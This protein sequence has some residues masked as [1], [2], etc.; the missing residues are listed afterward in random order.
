MTL[1]SPQSE[2]RLPVVSAPAENS[3]R[4]LWSASLVQCRRLLI[5][6]SRDWTTTVQALV[7]PALMMLMFLI[8]FG[9]T[10][11]EATGQRAVYG[12][13]P[14]V[15]L[16]AAMSGG[17]VSGIGLAQEKHSGLLTRFATLPV[18]R[19]AGLVGRMLAEAIRVLVTTLFILGVGV[20]FGFRFTQ[21][22]L[23]SIALVGLPV[24]FA[25][26]FAVLVTAL[27]A[28]AQPIAMINVVG[29]G[30]TLLMFFNSGFVPVAAYPSWLQDTVANQ[31]MSCAIEAM[32]GL[33]TGGPVAESLLETVAWTAGLIAVFGWPAVRGLRRAA[34]G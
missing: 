30:T 20:C 17:V 4:A 1:T 24:L 16:V 12:Y 8:V 25:L 33:S 11:A 13:A 6:W 29:I 19:A 18:H 22:P 27:A 34:A 21:G 2:F 15:A 26:G 10:V 9:N 14:M 31:P 3:A 32:R 23:A 5:T 7:Y 28:G